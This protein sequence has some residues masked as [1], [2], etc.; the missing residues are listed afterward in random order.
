MDQHIM[1][2]GMVVSESFWEQFSWDI[3]F[4]NITK[5]ELHQ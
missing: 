2:A 4:G 1:V 5:I 3:L